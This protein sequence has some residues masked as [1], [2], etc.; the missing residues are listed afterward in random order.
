[1]IIISQVAGLARRLENIDEASTDG[2]PS[3]KRNAR[4]DLFKWS[5]RGFGSAGM[6]E[7]EDDDD[8]GFSQNIKNTQSNSG[9]IRGASGEAD[10]FNAEHKNQFTKSLNTSER[11]K[12]TQMLDTWEEPVEDRDTVRMA[13]FVFFNLVGLKSHLFTTGKGVHSGYLAIQAN[14]CFHGLILSFFYCVRPCRQERGV[15]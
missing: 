15:R 7:T 13:K 1:M 5:F 12:L 2:G 6:I 9:S 11:I 4:D 10:E 14:A 3:N 8:D